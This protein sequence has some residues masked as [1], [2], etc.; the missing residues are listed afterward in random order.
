VTRPI[1]ATGYTGSMQLRK[2]RLCLDCE[3]IHEA[4]Q[5]P[6][7]ASEEFAYLTRWIIVEE[8]RVNRQPTARRVVPEK[9][10]VARWAQRGAVGL[11]VLAAGRWL[12]Q[13]SRAWQDE[14]QG[15]SARQVEEEHLPERRRSIRFERR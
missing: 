14:P 6:V 7:C 10:G 1:K 8:R 2:A 13:S 5:C 11:A 3:E 12:W 9:S 4:Q 15:N